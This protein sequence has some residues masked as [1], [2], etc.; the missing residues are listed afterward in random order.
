[1]NKVINSVIDKTRHD[2]TNSKRGKQRKQT[3]TLRCN[4]SN[5]YYGD[6]ICIKV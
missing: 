5:N 2:K 6:Q 4:Y 3:A 1:M